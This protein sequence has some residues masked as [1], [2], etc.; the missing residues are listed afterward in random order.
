AI[1]TDSGWLVVDFKT[2]VRREHEPQE[3]F[4]ARMRETYQGQLQGYCERLS[5]IDGRTATAAIF[6]LDTGDWIQFAPAL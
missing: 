3:V 6:A 5:Q 4:E 2:G 1:S